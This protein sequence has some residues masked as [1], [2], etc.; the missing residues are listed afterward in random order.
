MTVLAL[1]CISHKPFCTPCVNFSPHIL[2]GTLDVYQNLKEAIV[3]PVVGRAPLLV[4]HTPQTTPDHRPS[5]LPQSCSKTLLSRWR[6]WPPSASA[7]QI[8]VRFSK[9]CGVLLWSVPW[10]SPGPSCGRDER[11]V[12]LWSSVPTRC[13]RMVR[14]GGPS[15]R[16]RCPPLGWGGLGR[17]A[18]RFAGCAGIACVST[19]RRFRLVRSADGGG[20]LEIWSWSS[21]STCL[22]WHPSASGSARKKYWIM[23]FRREFYYLSFLRIN[24]FC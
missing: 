12:R 13:G 2:V 20:C 10:W 9:V 19:R 5:N 14:G 18:G 23:C 24:K 8:R 17:T 11:V 16:S 3:S 21:T 22:A 15:P 4:R 7:T 6:R 1:Q